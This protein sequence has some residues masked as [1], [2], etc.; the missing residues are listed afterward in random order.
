M[1]A[2]LRVLAGELGLLLLS[3]SA[4]GQI[5]TGTVSGDVRDSAGAVVPNAKVT[6]SSEG[7][8]QKIELI[9]NDSGLFLSGPLSPGSYLVEVEAKGFSKAAKRIPLEVNERA[10]LTFVLEVG[11]VTE[12]VTVQAEVPVLQTESATLSD[13]R[14]ERAVK[15]LPLNG[16]NFTQLIQ[17]SAGAIPAWPSPPDSGCAEARHPERLHQRS[18]P[19]AEQHPDRRHQQHGKPQWERN[20]CCIHPLT[21]FWNFVW[22]RVLPMS[23]LGAAAVVPSIW[24]TS[25]VPRIFMAGFTGSCGTPPLMPRTISI[26]RMLPFR[27]SA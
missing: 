11:T 9:S 27:R 13:V 16:R 23:N 18:A 25:P 17:L 15:D 8:G 20:P 5:D 26:W 4:Y 2:C 6:I 12:T 19:L 7:T 3:L 22:N 21:R 1:R 10:A 24:C 14:T